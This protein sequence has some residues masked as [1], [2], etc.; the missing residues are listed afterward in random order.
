MSLT[1][2]LVKETKDKKLDNHVQAQAWEQVGIRNGLSTYKKV[3]TTLQLPTVQHDF[4][5]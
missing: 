2:I 3:E 1:A 4:W 5:L